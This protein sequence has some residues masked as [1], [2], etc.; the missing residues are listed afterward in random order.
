MKKGVVLVLSV[1]FVL[2][3]VTLSFAASKKQTVTRVI[4]TTTVMS[5]AQ[6]EALAAAAVEKLNS[7]AWMIRLTP[8]N[9][10]KAPAESDVLTFSGTSM[11]SRNLS[12]KG[13]S[14]S[15][16][17]PIVREDSSVM[18]ETVQRLGEDKVAMWRVEL[19]GDNIQGVLAMRTINGPASLYIFTS[20]MPSAAVAKPVSVVKPV[21]VA[22]P[23]AAEPQKK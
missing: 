11:S 19:V 7:Q 15:N 1:A 4:T 17:T 14:S 13:Y 10:P 18:L 21:S 23:Q 3:F 20:N 22:K 16:F 9:S 12:E 2:S 8:Q 5:Q 6:T